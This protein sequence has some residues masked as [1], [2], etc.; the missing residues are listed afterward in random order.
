MLATF[1][2][3]SRMFFRKGKVNSSQN[4]TAVYVNRDRKSKK[5]FVDNHGHN[6]LKLSDV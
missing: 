2:V 1:Q 5:T 6:I 3:W 4:M